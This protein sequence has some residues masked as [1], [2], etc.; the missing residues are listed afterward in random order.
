MRLGFQLQLSGKQLVSHVRSPEFKPQHLRNNQLGLSAAS[1][2]LSALPPICQTN[3]DYQRREEEGGGHVYR[4]PEESSIWDSLQVSVQADVTEVHHGVKPHTGCHV[5][6]E[7]TG[8]PSTTDAHSARLLSCSL[9]A[10]GQ[11]TPLDISGML[12][13]ECQLSRPPISLS[14]KTCPPG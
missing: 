6:R 7:H 3:T 12:S 2:V 8:R 11:L 9:S 5:C 4:R 10:D 14:K 13:S 1:S